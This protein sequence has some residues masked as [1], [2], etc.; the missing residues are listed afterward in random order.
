[1]LHGG[2][3][4]PEYFGVWAEYYSKFIHAYEKEGIPIW[5]LT[6]QNEPLASQ[7]W[8]S[9]IYTAEE[10]RDF[11]KNY[12]GPTL[13]KDG[14]QDK[15]IIIWDHNRGIMYQR[16]AVPLDDPAAAQYIWGIGF[17]WYM[18]DDFENVK[19]VKEAFPADP[20]AVYRRLQLS[21][22]F[23]QNQR[24]A[25]RRDLRQINGQRFQ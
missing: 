20:P 14:L 10:E 24:L 23:Q 16:A 21:L 6:V 3:L 4:K 13:R 19:R 12:L 25:G 8:E 9:C 1:M 17:H 18:G 15:K 11:V 7:S 22:R 2:K 5:G